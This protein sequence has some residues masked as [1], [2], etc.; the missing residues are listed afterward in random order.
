M[1]DIPI[2][3]FRLTDLEGFEMDVRCFMQEADDSC[4]DGIHE[5][6]FVCPT[7]RET[8]YGR[9]Y[10]RLTGREDITQPFIRLSILIGGCFGQVK[11]DFQLRMISRSKRHPSVQVS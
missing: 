2:P 1:V 8:D 11:R 5:E 6:I 10:I 7:I 9:F 4:A 3:Y